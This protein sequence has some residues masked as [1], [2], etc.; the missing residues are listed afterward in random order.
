MAS[1]YVAPPVAK[2]K[3]VYCPN[4]GGPVERRGFG[5][6]LSIVCP[7]CKSVL[8]ASTPLLQILQRVEHLQSAYQPLIPLGSRG[9]LFNVSWEA[10]GY[11]VRSVTVEG[12]RFAW[13]EYLLFNP[14][15][16]FRYLTQYN[17]HWN[18]VTALESVPQPRTQGAK[19]TVTFENSTY[20]HFSSAQVTTDFVLGE[21]P[22]RVQFGDTLR[23]DDF[24]SPPNILSRE[25]TKEET[26]WSWGVY[27][28]G[29][30]IWK[31][32]ALPGAP[33]PARGV[34]LNQPSPHTGQ[35][36][37]YWGTF[38][39]LAGILLLLMLMFVAFSKRETVLQQ[40]Y[41]FASGDA[42]E[43]SFVTPEFDLNGRDANLELR[44]NTDLSNNWAFFNFALINENTGE[45]MDFSREVSYYFGS[46]SDGAWTEGDQ[47]STVMLPAV[48]PGRYY[49]RVEPDM[50]AGAVNYELVVRH[51]VPSFIWFLLTGALLLIPPVL[52]TIRAR[53]FESARW[54]ESD[55]APTSS[56]SSDDD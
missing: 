17:G 29:A 53:K 51:D 45:A 24:I 31:A 25:A 32:F 7:A 14:Y 26:T 52:Y 38:I 16:G 36:A 9:T 47:A 44:I 34:Y 30:D 8:D 35:I 43:P 55:Y 4:C 21:F 10:I 46:D 37:G 42:T 18:W 19:P 11:Q 41:H 54:A 39:K 6:T 3:A 1:P 40:R 23:G 50:D 27:T 13:E 20:Q 2:P 12:E 33:P 56:S 48:P 22:W 5:H 49:L 28:N 15:H